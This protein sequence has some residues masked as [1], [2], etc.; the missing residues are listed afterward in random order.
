MRSLLRL[1]CL[2]AVGL[3]PSFA[4]GGDSEPGVDP[5]QTALFEEYVDAYV[6]KRM[7]PDEAGIALAVVGPRTVD[8]GV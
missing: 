3:V 5:E 1:V 2:I 8:Q 7:E 6:A 4:C